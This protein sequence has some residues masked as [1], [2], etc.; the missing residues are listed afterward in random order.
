MRHQGVPVP[1][2]ICLNWLVLV[3][4]LLGACGGGGSSPGTVTEA[5]SP[6]KVTE[7]IT[8]YSMI[9]NYAAA[10]LNNDGLEDV[11]VSGW[12]AM[13]P[14]YSGEVNPGSGTWS[15]HYNP[16]VMVK[17]LLQQT[18]GNLQ[19][20]TPQWL[21]D[22]MIWGSNRVLIADLDGD[23][24]KD[25]VLPGFQDTG[26]FA[27]VPSV[28][29]WNTGTGFTRDDSTLSTPIWSHGGCLVDVN[30]DGKTDIVMGTGSGGVWRNLGN[31]RFAFD[32][33]IINNAGASCASDRDATSGRQIVV[34]GNHYSNDGMRDN[35]YLLGQDGA[36]L[37]TRGLPG[38]ELA[39][40]TDDTALLF[41]DIDLDGQNDLLVT[42]IGNRRRRAYK[43]LGNW[44]FVDYSTAWLSQV[45]TQSYNQIST[46]YLAYGTQRFVFLSGGQADTVFQL[47]NQGLMPVRPSRFVDVVREVSDSLG[48][49]YNAEGYQSGFV[50]LSPALGGIGLLTPVP[51][52]NV[53]CQNTRFTE[54]CSAI[55]FYSAPY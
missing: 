35:M 39:L 43:N 50:Y 55:H 28:V 47:S 27:P 44:N 17:I 52:N 38:T 1:R 25:V 31:R 13:G 33:S 54:H 10:D 8:P 15:G 42:G 53:N 34:S 41:T 20:A 9:Y 23:G 37:E 24:F 4:A 19:D 51:I 36:L 48:F 49:A 3:A 45:D 22:N 26:D 21:M 12:M 16:K 5:A 7:Y 32:A 6:H 46:R 2:P 29:L 14:G 18:D 30:Q 11:V 40:N